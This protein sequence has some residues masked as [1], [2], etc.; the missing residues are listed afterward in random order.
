MII[1]PAILLYSEIVNEIYLNNLN[2]GEA[3]ILR[4]TI[5]QGFD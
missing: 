2:G 4:G 3:G 1:E 5:L